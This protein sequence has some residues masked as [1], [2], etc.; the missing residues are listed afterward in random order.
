[1][2]TRS[3]AQTVDKGG[4]EFG[5]ELI[6]AGSTPDAAPGVGDGQNGDDRDGVPFQAAGR[7]TRVFRAAVHER[8]LAV[9]TPRFWL[10]SAAVSLASW[11]LAMLLVTVLGTGEELHGDSYRWAYILTGAALTV[12]AALAGVLWGLGWRSRVHCPSPSEPVSERDGGTGPLPRWFEA[13]SRGVVFALAAFVFLLVLAFGSGGPVETA[14]VAAIVMA[15]ASAAFGGI[16]A[17]AA[18]WLRPGAARTAACVVAA[19]LLLGN[20]VAVVALLPAVRADEPVLVAINVER[21]DL[22]RVVHFECSPEF[23]GIAEVFHTERIFWLAVS[24]PVIIFTLLAGEASSPP[25]SLGWLPGELQAAAEGRHD[26]C[27]EAEPLEESGLQIPLALSGLAA[28]GVLAGIFL[29]GGAAA[30]RRR[31]VASR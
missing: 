15:V 14:V 22:G 9:R 31:E 6:G 28:Q 7:T 19:F 18:A 29:I 27:L 3:E 4:E 10:A 23:A 30:A 12:V 17:G 24:N 13:A 1:M 2:S 8:L 26:A 5:Y 25:D 16:G 11:G 21:D 20:V